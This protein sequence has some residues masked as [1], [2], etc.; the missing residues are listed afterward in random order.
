[1]HYPNSPNFK[2]QWQV[3]GAR[4]EFS[5]VF[6]F[7]WANGET[8][9]VDSNRLVEMGLGGEGIASTALAGMKEK[10]KRQPESSVVSQVRS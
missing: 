2:A 10:D 3:L 1:M 6:K 8:T 4:P 7:Q 9:S 5:K